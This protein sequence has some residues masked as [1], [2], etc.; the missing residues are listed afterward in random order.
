MSILNAEALAKKGS[1]VAPRM[2]VVKGSAP[3]PFLKWAGGKR[4]LLPKIMPNIPDFACRYI[5]PFLG[6]GAVM[7][8]QPSD[9]IKIVNDFN[10]ELIQVYETIRDEPENLIRLLRDMKNTK[11]YFLEIRAWDRSPA[12]DAKSAAERSARF[13]FLNKTCFNGL[14]RVNSKGFFNVPY[15]Y[16][17]NPDWVAAENIKNVSEFL[18]TRIDGEFAVSLSSGDY[19]GATRKAA[20]GDF[21]YLDPPY[22]PVSSTS[23]FVAYQEGGFGAGDQAELRDEVI[24]LTNLG[25]PVLL[26]NSNAPIIHELYGDESVFDIQTVSTSRVISARA[27]GRGKI[28]EVLINNYRAAGIRF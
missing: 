10:A 8:S 28:D 4:S 3:Q 6:A 2:R 26:S 22:A 15:G 16:P 5:E 17:V 1:P 11:E 18:N 20:G 13:I 27:A 23:S 25:V 12:F 14:H 21:V 9:R 19:R 24:R 7:F